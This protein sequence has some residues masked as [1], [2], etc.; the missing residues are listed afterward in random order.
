MVGMPGAVQQ[1][2]GTALGQAWPAPL[3]P[4]QGDELPSNECSSLL[5]QLL[6]LL[7]HP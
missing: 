2:V 4:C 3:H 7:L 6:L 5:R 1:A